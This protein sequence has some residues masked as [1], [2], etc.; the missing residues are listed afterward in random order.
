MGNKLISIALSAMLLLGGPSAAFANPVGARVQV[1]SISKAVISVGFASSLGAGSAAGSNVLGVS[2]SP[3][4]GV[5]NLFVPQ[6]A[7]IALPPT[8][9]PAAQ[10]SPV[11]QTAQAEYMQPA[12]LQAVDRN[13]LISVINQLR[14]IPG[15]AKLL[16][17][18]GGAASA[19]D[20]KALVNKMP[21]GAAKRDMLAF[22]AALETFGGG[23]VNGIFDGSSAPKQEAA[24]VSG[25]YAWLSRRPIGSSLRKWAEAKAEASRPKAE[26]IDTDQFLLKGK[27][28]RWTPNEGY[29]PDT[30]LDTK[31]SYDGV[32]G[33]DD[34]LEAIRFGLT[35]W[36]KQ[37]NLIVSGPGG[38]GRKTAIRQVL[39][40]HAAKRPTPTD[41][42]SATNFKDTENPIILEMAAGEGR[43]FKGA[44]EAVMKEAPLML[45][46]YFSSGK[47]AQMQKQ[48]MGS[49]AASKADR[50]KAI[51]RK[52]A[53]I[54]VK[55]E[56]GFQIGIVK[57]EDGVSYNI[58]AEPT[59]N[60]K[61]L[62][63]EE[64]AEALKGKP[65]SQEELFAELGEVS[66]PLLEE[67]SQILQRDMQEQAD[68]LKKLEEVQA[69]IAQQ[70]FSQLTA[71]VFQ[72]ASGAPT[73]D[74]Q[75]HVTW[76]ENQ[77]K[78]WAEL[79]AKMQESKIGP[80]RLA[81]TQD[82]GIVMVHGQ[83]TVVTP[84]VFEELKAKGVVSN[85]D[86]FSDYAKRALAAAQPLLAMQDE[87]SNKINAEH[88]AI[89]ADDPPM[90]Q[91]R[92]QT[93]EWLESFVGH[94]TKNY[95][96]FV[97][98][99]EQQAQMASRGMSHPSETVNVS[100]LADNALTKGA[101]MVY[102]EDH[103]IHGL[104]GEAEGANQMVMI[105]GMSAPIKRKAPGGPV[106]KAGSYLQA[107]GGYLVADLLETLRSG[108]YP[109][110]M[111]MIRSGQAEIVE[112]GEMG[113]ASRQGQIFKIDTKGENLVK[114]IFIASPM[115]KMMLEHNDEFFATTF[116]A[117]AEFE[118]SFN[119]AKDTVKAY[120]SFLRKQIEL[121]AHLPF[122]L[123]NLDKGAIARV[124]EEAAK[125]AGSNK[126]LTA[127]FGAVLA[128]LKE[129]SQHTRD[130]GRDLVTRADVSAIIDG[131]FNRK[132]GSIK[133]YL[134][135]RH[136]SGSSII[137]VSGEKQGQN[138][139]LAVVGGMFGVPMR[140]TYVA[141]ARR[142]A[143]LL[144]SRDAAAN[145]AG[146]S[147]LK[148]VGVIEGFFENIFARH[149]SI[150]A[151]VSI[152]FA[153]SNNGIDG[154]SATQTMAYGALSAYSGSKIKQ[155]I[156]MT[157]AMDQFGN[158]EPIGGENEKITGYYDVLVAML[159]A[160]GK[161]L[162]GTQGV[163]IPATNAEGLMLRP[164][165]A[166]AVAD[167]KFKIWA[168]DHVSQGVEILMDRSYSEV[169]RD[170]KIYFAEV[171]KQ[172]KKK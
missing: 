7:L 140:I 17:E 1:G 19:Q 138:N 3:G 105:P 56:W 13:P 11:M 23:R 5:S 110:L 136:V 55:G 100:L 147:F 125:M 91:S 22:S 24:K 79:E 160:E 120:L 118:H 103:S 167:G 72:L 68:A 37:Y 10:V 107:R 141:S 40:K 20:V 108:S 51:K 90:P 116:R 121:S 164:D 168:I 6:D 128:V 32:V 81:F 49:I 58:I 101:P 50:D 132:L 84:K 157:G 94:L 36:G 67:Y 74:N 76:K 82:G 102:A 9:T 46:Q 142:G 155:G 35:M 29:L 113:L 71:P 63:E 60:G 89:H 87:I 52:T 149:K 85:E 93:I 78:Y 162:D 18:F 97:A 170:S 33:Q 114:V 83:T 54:K 39:P 88:E 53:K 31:H 75:A 151:Q 166:K 69:Q 111:R 115:M 143:P 171:E 61:V 96:G 159:E 148:S 158:I 161:A 26:K 28:V 104:F 163:I 135:E 34:A 25:F 41:V 109:Y 169:I 65:Y 119:I 12:Q 44:I 80:F 112:G 42:V 62:N 43:E 127:Q 126:K 124:L 154:D 59:F 38:T 152:E 153:Q 95:A 2:L 45:Q 16:Q 8:Q 77:E 21:E 64:V 106:L 99:P 144:V 98:S 139:G 129:A 131:R 172:S 133:R 4:L 92:K 134:K 48:L 73:H 165:I 130:D 14:E 137:E 66:A 27:D 146:S 30:A 70:V 15:G 57:G 145:T 47:F 123:L 156:A 150:P 86:Q 122:K 117:V